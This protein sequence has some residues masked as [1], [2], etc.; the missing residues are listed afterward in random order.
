MEDGTEGSVVFKLNIA[1][2]P[3][4]SKGSGVTEEHGGGG[5]GG[6]GGAEEQGGGVQSRDGM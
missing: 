1:K 4:Q 3:T 5:G 2:Q 6:G